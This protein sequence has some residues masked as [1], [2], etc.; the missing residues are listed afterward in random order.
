MDSPWRYRWWRPPL[1]AI[2]RAINDG[3]LFAEGARYIWDWVAS[4]LKIKP[5]P[6]WTFDYI[7]D[8]ER[9]HC[10]SSS[11]YFMTDGNEE[12]DNNYSID[13]TRI[14]GLI[15]RLE[16]TGHE[17]GFHG[18]FNSYNDYGVFADEKS[19]LDQLVSNRQ[20]G[21]RQ[22]YLRWKTPET[23]RIW[24]EAGML[25]DATLSYADH[26]GFRCGICLPFKPF[27]VLEDR[28]LDIWELPLTVMDRMLESYRNLSPEQAY[29]AIR[30]LLDI[31]AE[32]HGLFVMLWHNSHLYEIEFPGWRDLH[33]RAV[34]ECGSRA[35]FSG[36]GR[37]IIRHWVENLERSNP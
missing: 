23:W 1:K 20:Y 29:E 11:F 22:H 5:D 32:H 13:N 26:E 28:V 10:L 27:D 21:G 34:E 4:S 16:N 2:A 33:E 24:E 25:Y 14:I 6:G 19:R 8:I 7:V 9:R 15:R 37:D 36:N 12:Y 31:V 3:K 35:V 30:K 17:I 18:S